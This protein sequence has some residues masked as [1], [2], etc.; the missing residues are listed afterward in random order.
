MIRNMGWVL[1][2]V[3]G[4]ALAPAGCKS[5]RQQAAQEAIQAAQATI[6]EVRGEAEKYV[7]EQ[8]HDAQTTIQQAKDTLEKGDYPAALTAAQ[9]ALNQAKAVATQTISRQVEWT[10]LNDSIT[11][12][13]KEA[14]AKLDGYASGARLPKGLSRS[15]LNQAKAQYEQ[16]KQKWEE[17]WAESRRDASKKGEELKGEVEKVKHQLELSP[18]EVQELVRAGTLPAV[19]A[20]C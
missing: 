6:S 20:D 2:A 4:I 5:S 3:I 8:S 9:N 1:C 18:K 13:L 19:T 10:D 16:L 11:K 7:P 12:S 17:T 14:K 15:K